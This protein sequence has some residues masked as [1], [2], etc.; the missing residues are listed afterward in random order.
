MHFISKQL[1][2]YTPKIQNFTSGMQATIYLQHNLY[3]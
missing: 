3:I 2:N 1:E